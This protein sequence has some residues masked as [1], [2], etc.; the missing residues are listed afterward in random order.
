MFSFEVT[1][2][3]VWVIKFSTFI[4]KTCRCNQTERSSEVQTIQKHF[5]Y[6]WTMA[7]QIFKNVQYLCVTVINW[8]KI[9]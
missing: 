2:R 1:Q 6:K 8:V 7:K 5:K 9:V 4:I 3:R